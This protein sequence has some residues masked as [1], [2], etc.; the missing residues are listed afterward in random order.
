MSFVERSYPDIVRDVLTGLTQ[1]VTGEVHRVDYNPAARPVVVPEIVLARRPVRRVS[2]V[3]GFVAP[4]EEGSP[5]VARLFSLDDYELVPNPDDPADLS[6]IRFRPFA[7]ARPAPG[8]DV[9]VNYYPRTTDPTPLT[10][11]NVGSVTRTLVEAVSREVAGLYAQL[12]IAYDSGFVETA[13]GPS[14]DRV[15]ALLSYSRFK[16]GRAVGSVTFTRRAGATGSIT[17]PAGTPITDA[18]D[19]LRYVT[20]ERYD[21]LAGESTA[22]VRVQGETASTPTVAEGVLTVVQRAIAGVDAVTNPRPTARA[23]EDESDE[24]L[25][26]R[27]RDALLAANKGTLEA[28]RD[29]LLALPSVKDV[30]IEEFPNGVAGEIRVDIQLAAGPAETLPPEV[31]ERIEALR[32]AGIRVLPGQAAVAVL[33]A[34]VAL[35]LA[36]LSLPAAEVEA[37]HRGVRERLVAEIGKRAVG[38]KVRVKPLIAALLTD[39]RIVDATV[40]IGRSGGAP[41]AD[42]FAPGSG[43]GTSLAAEAVAFDADSFAVLPPSDAEKVSVDVAGVFGVASVAGTPLEAIRAEIEQKLTAYA[44]KLAPGQSIDAAALLQA[45]K[46]DA[47]YAI[48]PLRLR[49]TLAARDEFVEIRQGGVAYVVQAGQS[50]VVSSVELAT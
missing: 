43:E 30:A 48:D 6:R 33:A 41:V 23:S 32:P 4:A 31:I 46:N 13:T 37:I 7:R 28:I 49:V 14:L 40:L 36:G 20:S 12:N 45:L 26:A 27:A 1:G 9:V 24:A 11:L 29:G 50:F 5:P 18:A 15:V 16:A 19:T 42:D 39:T 35:V 22:E 2:M 47:R 21:L 8:T 3:R 38:E 17:I 10:D 44:A 25:R 34:R